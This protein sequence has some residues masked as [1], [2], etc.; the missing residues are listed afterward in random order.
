MKR[1]LVIV[2]VGA[3]SLHAEWLNLPYANRNFDLVLSFYSEVA[4]K[5]FIPQIGVT[6]TFISGGKW[7]G[8]YKTF[9]DVDIHSYD[10]FWLPDDDIST[11][12][13]EINGIF[14]ICRKHKLAV[15]QP[16]L[17]HSSYFSFWPV[18][19]C[20]SFEIRYTNFVEI[21]APV[22][23]R[24]VLVKTLPL[25]R[26][27]RSG[28]G[29]DFIWTRLDVSGPRRCALID[30]ISVTHTRPVGK[31]LVSEMAKM[32]GA[33][34]NEEMNVLDAMF[35]TEIYRKI[36]NFSGILKSGIVIKNRPILAF[37]ILLGYLSTANSFSNNKD[38][39]RVGVV[40]RLSKFRRLIKL[41]KGIFGITVVNKLDLSD[42]TPPENLTNV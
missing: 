11:G 12:G 2:R 24:S 33:T 35:D 41:I 39:N 4:Y 6:G 7:D 36:V 19:N 32:G 9:A 14:R 38:L 15:A 23:D 21:M 22:L 30:A 10:Y 26:N 40:R 16:T 25:F 20:K 17:T 8:L 13:D 42:L 3:Q 31:H 27:T 5:Q 28:F 18:L 1:N 34:S 37:F 29:L